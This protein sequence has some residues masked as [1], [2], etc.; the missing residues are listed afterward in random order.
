M[1]RSTQRHLET[2]Q[3]FRSHADTGIRLNQLVTPRRLD[4][5][6]ARARNQ[7]RQPPS[8]LAAYVLIL[9]TRGRFA[10]R[11]RDEL[12]LHMHSHTQRVCRR[13]QASPSPYGHPQQPRLYGTDPATP[14]CDLGSSVQSNFICSF[15]QAHASARTQ[16]T[17]TH[18]VLLLALCRQFFG[19]SRK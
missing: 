8:N 6:G 7:S 19:G 10:V 17:H 2:W 1:T 5:T 15:P 18:E 12:L 9:C 14:G 11:R 4:P 13:V 16:H 3:P